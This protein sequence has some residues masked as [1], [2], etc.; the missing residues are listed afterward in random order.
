MSEKTYKTV[1]A[2]LNEIY[3]IYNKTVIS[4]RWCESFEI[5]DDR[6]RRVRFVHVAKI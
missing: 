3:G 6:K 2:V 1:K 4:I 5:L